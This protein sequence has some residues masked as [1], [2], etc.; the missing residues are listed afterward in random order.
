MLVVLAIAFTAGWIY[1]SPIY[2]TKVASIVAVLSVV[3]IVEL[4]E[5]FSVI[6]TKNDTIDI[7]TKRVQQLYDDMKNTF[8]LKS[9]VA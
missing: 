1:L 7:S 4:V 9:S 6:S 8:A 2:S 3:T 5:A